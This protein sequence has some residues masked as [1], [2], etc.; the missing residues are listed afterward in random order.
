MIRK[1]VDDS[2]FSIGYITLEAR[3]AMYTLGEVTM[4]MVLVGFGY[5]LKYD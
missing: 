2:I 3:Y 4:E 5:T 1:L